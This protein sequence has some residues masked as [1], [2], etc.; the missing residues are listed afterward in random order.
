MYKPNEVFFS[1]KDDTEH[2]DKSYLSLFFKFTQISFNHSAR[3]RSSYIMFNNLG[4][5]VHTFCKLK[6][7]SL[8]EKNER[9]K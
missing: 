3:I 6:L 2:I 7:I 4:T 9:D 8:I 1:I 5:S